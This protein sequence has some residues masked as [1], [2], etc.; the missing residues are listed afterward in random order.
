MTSTHPLTSTRGCSAGTSSG[1]LSPL[2]RNLNRASLREEDL[3]VLRYAWKLGREY[4]R[5]MS[6]YRGEYTPDW[7]QFP[8]GSTAIVPQD[9]NTPVPSDAPNIVYTKEDDYAID[10]WLKAKRECSL[11]WT[12]TSYH[13]TDVAVMTAWH[14]VS[15]SA[16]RD[17]ENLCLNDW[18]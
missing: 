5:R 4:G 8:Q 15:L 10:E 16:S 6:S 3:V 17:L 2:R 9:H 11:I 14:S 18:I 7:P 12:V 13:L 1:F